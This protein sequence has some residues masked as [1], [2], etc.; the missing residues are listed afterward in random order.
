MWTKHAEADHTGKPV[1]KKDGKSVPPTLSVNKDLKVAMA[2]AKT[3]AEV[4]AVMTQ[5]NLN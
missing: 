4:E 1:A 5:F 2:A 3:E